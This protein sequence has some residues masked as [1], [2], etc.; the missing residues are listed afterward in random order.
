MDSGVSY[1]GPGSYDIEGTQRSRV[2]TELPRMVRFKP[3]KAPMFRGKAESYV[4][5]GSY[6]I[7]KYN[8]CREL[9]FKGYAVSR[10]TR[11]NFTGKQSSSAMLVVIT[12]CS[13][14]LAPIC[15]TD[16]STSKR[17]KCSDAKCIKKSR[18]ARRRG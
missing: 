15:R 9:E 16:M 10:E 17:R 5:P 1:V 3:S 13:Q 14:D 6:N 18:M 7:N 12:L 8:L 2:K 4:G 11:F